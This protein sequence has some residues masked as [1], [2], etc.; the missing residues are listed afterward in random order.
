MIKACIFDLD[1]TLADTLESM[2]AVA[3]GILEEF[4]FSALPA[5]NY[6]YYCG[7]GADKLVER[8]LLDA[9]D[10]QLR[11]LAEGQR[12]Y[13]ERFNKDPLFH[14]RRYPGITETLGTLKKKGMKLGV[15][16]NKPHPAAL[17]VVE[18]MFPELFDCIQGQQEG[19]RRKP[20]PDGA[21]KIADRLGTEP[22]ECLYIGDTAVDMK[23]GTAAGMHTAGVLWG[24]RDK[25]ELVEAGAEQL[26]ETPEDLLDLL[27][28]M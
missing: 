7:D 22:Q 12:L 4:G 1:G 8:V 3:N 25:K 13:R 21:L 15:C 11:Y 10:A 18:T 19:I 6:R 2:A 24:F 17:T 9:G 14:V 5:D 23:T 16:T 20:F 26:A 28:E 27:F